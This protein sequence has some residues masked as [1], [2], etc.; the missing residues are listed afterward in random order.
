MPQHLQDL[1]KFRGDRLFNGAVNVDWFLTDD[2]KRT[3]AAKAFLF[4]GPE[5]HGVTQQDVGL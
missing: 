4:H 2:I 5:Y 3:S 1:V